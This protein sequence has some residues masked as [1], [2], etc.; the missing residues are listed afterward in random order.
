MGYDTGMRLGEILKIRWHG[1]DFQN[2]EVRL[3]PGSTKN[4][5]PRTVPLFGELGDMLRMEH[6]RYPQTEFVFMRNDHRL[7]SFYKAW[8]SACKRAELDGLLFHDFRR[9]GVRNLVR[10]GVPERVAMAISGHK[11]R[12][13]FERYNIVSGRDLKDA[14]SKM[15]TY[16]AKQKARGTRTR[17]Q[18]L[19]DNTGTIANRTACD[20][21]PAQVN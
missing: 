15:K 13:V 8:G 17:R 18:V 12:T 3:D 14:A 10:A 7:G 20:Q 5:E 1:V 21:K 4:G 9:T 11:T 2:G 19:R 16:L 6:D